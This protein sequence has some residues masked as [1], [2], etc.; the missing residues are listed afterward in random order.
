MLDLPFSL[1]WTGSGRFHVVMADPSAAHGDGRFTALHVFS[2][3]GA[4]PVDWLGSLLPVDDGVSVRTFG[5]PR[6][7]A[8][9]VRLQ[10]SADGRF[11]RRHDF[12]FAAEVPIGARCLGRQRMVVA[13]DGSSVRLSVEPPAGGPVDDAD[14]A[15]AVVSARVWSNGEPDTYRVERCQTRIGR[16][17]PLAVEAMF[18]TAPAPAPTVPSSIAAI[19]QGKRRTVVLRVAEAAGEGAP[20][21][22]HL[23]RQTGSAV[24]RL[25]GETTGDGWVVSWPFGGTT[26]TVA[27]IT[28]EPYRF[29]FEGRDGDETRLGTV[30]RLRHDRSAFALVPSGD[31]AFEAAVSHGLVALQT[32]PRPT[33]A[34]VAAAVLHACR[35]TA[36]GDRA[37]PPP[38]NGSVLEALAYASDIRAR[39]GV[40]RRPAPVHGEGATGGGTMP[41]QIR[42]F[43][44]EALARDPDL[45]GRA[46]LSVDAD[47]LAEGIGHHLEACRAFLDVAT[48]EALDGA[49]RRWIRA[50]AKASDDEDRCRCRT[51]LAAFER[52]DDAR[53]GGALL[54]PSERTAVL[55]AIRAA[56]ERRRSAFAPFAA[57]AA[58][59]GISLDREPP[60]PADTGPVDLD[61][62]K[63]RILGECAVIDP[64][65]DTDRV[66]DALSDLD[67][68]DGENWLALQAMVSRDADRSRGPGLLSRLIDHVEGWSGAG[69]ALASILAASGGDRGRA[70][71]A[72][73]GSFVTAAPPLGPARDGADSWMHDLERCDRALRI[74]VGR[75]LDAGVDDDGPTVDQYAAYLR[76]LALHRLARA[77]DDLR[78]ELRARSGTAGSRLAVAVDWLRAALPDEPGL[79]VD[80]LAEAAK[81]L[82][83]TTFDPMEWQA[84]EAELKVVDE[85]A[86]RRPSAESPS[87]GLASE[88][89]TDD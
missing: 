85:L 42:A 71:Q 36:T 7:A 51:A 26:E 47:S 21:P 50:E 63:Q 43:H 61:A 76:V 72:L 89:M 5:L 66:R 27:L 13:A 84:L 31:E 24:E 6:E 25:T 56:A 37:D 70:L 75:L 34:G 55:D 44:G 10:E 17:R 16:D 57:V 65:I 80:R 11:G 39:A 86:C 15:D 22:V 4:C 30:L 48:A 33:P 1:F 60:A 68:E 32:P 38:T 79:L 87:A 40:M 41:P 83:R 18:A 35:P 77:A 73:V 58:M 69:P 29:T 74:A 54:E 78:A 53:S 59:A 28:R 46:G 67:P 2:L 64:A 20:V 49:R 9:G 8:A 12:T 23:L 81:V 52:L 45:V 62:V 14:D 82:G 88:T 19:R 3:A